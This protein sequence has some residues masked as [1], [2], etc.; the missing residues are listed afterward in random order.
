MPSAIARCVSSFPVTLVVLLSASALVVGAGCASSGH[1]AASEPTPQPVDGASAD[2]QAIFD[3][4]GSAAAA[5]TPALALFGEAGGRSRAEGSAAVG[6]NFRQVSFAVEG[7]DFDP[8]ISPDGERLYFAST[9]HAATA[10]IYVKSIDGRTVTQLTND[11]ASDVMPAVSPDGSRVAFASNRNGSWDLFVINA[12][13]GQAVEITSDAAAELHPSWSPDGRHIVYSKLGEVSGRWEIWI[14]EVNRNAVKRFL[15]YGLF[16]HWHPTQSR[17]AFQRARDRGE[18]LFS[19]WTFDL[20]RN[21]ATALTELASSPVAALVNPRWSPD[22]SRLAFA[23]VMNPQEARVNDRPVLA[24]IW[25]VDAKGGSR[26][27]LT[28]GRYSNLMPTWGPDHEVYFVSDRGGLDNV[29]SANTT[30][31]HLAALPVGDGDPHDPTAA[32]TTITTKSAP[33]QMPGPS[34]V[35]NDAPLEPLPATAEETPE[36][37]NVPLSPER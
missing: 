23:A 1:R 6:E 11:P 14:T 21:E 37:A 9:A 31:A 27:N 16:P 32:S 13:G 2:V 26:A 28:N 7:A 34:V 18:R 24:D 22:G 12:S 25:V 15:T 29:W 5:Y 10:D 8:S 30:Q 19:I 33:M 20:S 35:S 4:A 17:I 3:D 36:I